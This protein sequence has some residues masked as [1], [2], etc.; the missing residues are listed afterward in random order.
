MTIKFFQRF[1][2]PKR[3]RLTKRTLTVIII[4]TL[5]VSYKIA[6]EKTRGTQIR[7]N[8]AV[9]LMSKGHHEES[10]ILYEKV[11]K[12]WP[13]AKIAWTGKGICQMYLGR[14]EEAIASYD[15]NLEIDPAHLQS[16]KGKGIC[17]EKLGRY[18]EAIQC[19]QRIQDIKPNVL[20]A[21][22]HID[23]LTRK[24]NMSN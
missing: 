7:L 2:L 22:R 6:W 5:L 4:I 14:F 23:Q 9:I 20:N 8:K 16:L 15:S 21:Q 3:H 24:L 19:F 10:L 13:R 17:Y 18:N 12:R 11:L 1:T